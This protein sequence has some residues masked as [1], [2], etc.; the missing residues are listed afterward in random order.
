M[1][2][3]VI[4]RWGTHPRLVAAFVELIQKELQKVDANIRDQVIILF[5]AHSLPLKVYPIFPFMN[6]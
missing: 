6:N 3:S 4:D 2:W 1:K 5:S